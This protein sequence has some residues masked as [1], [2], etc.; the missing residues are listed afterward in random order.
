MSVSLAPTIGAAYQS[1]TNGGLP[2]NVGFIATYAAN[3]TT[4]QASYTTS[5]GNVANANPIPLDASGRP[6]GEIWFTDGVAYR[7]DILDA[8]SNLIKTYDN[9]YGI[10]KPLSPSGGSALIGFI[11]SGS[12]AVPRTV[13]SK[14]RD[15]ASPQDDGAA[16]NGSTD[17]RTAINDALVDYPMLS[18]GGFSY[19]VVGTIL[20]VSGSVLDG[21]TYN[22]SA[23]G[24]EFIVVPVTARNITLQNFSATAN[25]I[26][27]HANLAS[28]VDTLITG[29]RL[30]AGSYGVL[31][32]QNAANADGLIVANSYIKSTIGN[33]LSWNQLNKDGKNFLGSGL[34]LTSGTGG[35]AA[36]AA[37][38]SVA[39]TQG[40]LV[41]GAHLKTARLESIHLEDAFKRVVM[42]GMTAEST[43]RHGVRVIPC[44]TLQGVQD[45]PILM[46][47][48]MKHTGG[49]GDNGYDMVSNGN[50]LL[51]GVPVVG[52]VFESFDAALSSY[53][54]NVL[55]GNTGSSCNILLS[56]LGSHAITGGANFNRQ[57]AT[58]FQGGNACIADT[59]VS[60]VKPTA[61]VTKAGANFIG[62]ALKRL[63]SPI[64]VTHT[65][66]A[67][68]ENIG[69]VFP[70]PTRLSGKI[71]CMVD[72][73]A[74]GAMT[75]AQLDWDGAT[76]TVAI[77]QSH[78]AG[79]G[80]STGTFVESGGNIYWRLT[81][82]VAFTGVTAVM[83]FDGMYYKA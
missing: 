82:G 25:A 36:D 32:N 44:T 29:M 65:G 77:L 38:I 16:A 3:S 5:T 41:V 21:G 47:L 49:V 26:G 30:N 68:A 58:A 57:C 46:A 24:A 17:D 13:Q 42:V 40:A 31:W 22:Q 7:I 69:I 83:D 39:G 12:D 10:Q 60:E 15:T 37:C 33:S 2:N 20:L 28:P 8:D 19:S 53:G 4:P 78:Y 62:N 74:P 43:L 45:P 81:S 71:L 48:H 76:L 11:N 73:G 59:I 35:A 67:G 79:A 50:P 27:V 6:P 56:T 51:N 55:T 66:G 72:R 63:S 18:G 14:L 61:W 80:V 1:F 34:I 54:A 23:A 52:C 75:Y 9:V 70:T 64:T